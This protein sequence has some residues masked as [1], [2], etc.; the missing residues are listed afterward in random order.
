MKTKSIALVLSLFIACNLFAQQNRDISRKEVFSVG[1]PKSLSFRND[2]LGKGKDFS[3]WENSHLPFNSVTKKYL[4]EEVP[5]DSTFPAWAN[6][7]ARLHPE[8]LM[9]IHLNGESTSTEDKKAHKTF[10]PGHWVYE[11]GTKLS[12]NI[13]KEINVVEVDD[14]TVFSTSVHTYKAGDHKGEKL[15]LS[16]VLVS[17]N[18]NGEKDWYNSEFAIVEHIDTINNTLSLKRGQHFSTSKVFDKGAYIAP[19]AADHWG[20][21]LLWYYNLSTTCPRDSAGKNCA[22]RCFENL[23]KWF[24]KDGEL[25]N[26]DGIGYDI[27]Y[28]E[29]SEKHHPKW[30]LDNNGVADRGIFNGKNL[31]RTG[32]WELIR[33]TRSHFGDEFI[34]T[35]DG[36]NDDMQKAVGIMN[37]MESEG[38]CKPWD[39]F[40][41]VSRTINE[42]T[43]WNLYNNARYKFSYIH[44]K[45]MN[46]EANMYRYSD[47]RRFGLGLATC[48]SAA[49][50]AV[51]LPEMTGG[52]LNKN[53]WLGMPISDIK[54]PAKSTPDLLNNGG[55]VMNAGFV[56][57]FKFGNAHSKVI[58][59]ELHIKG[60]GPDIYKN[61][62]FFGPEVN[63][64]DGDLVIFLEAKA[65]EGLVDFEASDRVPRKVY[66]KLESPAGETIDSQFGFIGTAGFTPLCFYF[67]N[68]GKG[69]NSLRIKIE[70]EEQGEIALRN[71]SI[72][73]SPLVMVREFKKGVV[74]VNASTDLVNFD[75]GKALPGKTKLK[76]LDVHTPKY[77]FYDERE[78]EYHLLFNNGQKVKNLKEVE[79]PGL[80]ALFLLK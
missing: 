14:A 2:R 60:T 7:Y 4:N 34:I 78:K 75:L 54:Y 3:F 43:Y 55:V 30:D 49:Y 77:E 29:V 6:Q 56:R 80:N 20:G 23:V 70:I 47:L 19:I 36:W 9:L 10:F 21:Y 16:V 61:L 64:T 57:Q 50:T 62:A 27:N 68:A 63:I 67:R 66:A 33:K 71:F 22:D 79:V 52:E 59:N 41:E 15:P 53:N 51:T 35:S 8:K 1:F 44:F 69:K 38:I 12:E 40:R 58:N 24:G 28:F 46:D 11:A 37:G 26:L 31:F 65:I 39:A 74:L 18:A 25:E 45:L 73:N 13:S 48:L 76:H 5:I 17:D 72:H 32:N 42:H